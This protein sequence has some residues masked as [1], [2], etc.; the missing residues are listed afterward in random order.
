MSVSI[1]TMIEKIK[2]T[3][4][5]ID[6][7]TK[8]VLFSNQKAK[9][10]IGDKNGNIDLDV[11]FDS[12]DIIDTFLLKRNVGEI[13]DIYI[14]IAKSNEL[15][16]V[17]LYLG[18]FDQAKTQVYIE[19]QPKSDIKKMFEAMQELSTDILFMINID[20]HLLFFRGEL[21]KQLGL[22]ENIIN[23]PHALIEACVIHPEDIDTYLVT[24]D[25][26]LDGIQRSCELR[27]K[28]A[29]GNFN[30]FSLT[31]V[32]VYND[33]R[34][35]IKVLGK[36]Q[37][38]Q[39]EKDLQF[40]MSHDLLTKTLNKISLTNC[41]TEILHASDEGET[42]ALY[43]IDVD[44]FSSISA[45]FTHAFGDKLL[46]NIGRILLSCVRDT[47]LVG[48]V[49]IDEFVVFL[50]NIV[51]DDAIDKKAE[52]IL[53]KLAQEFKYEGKSYT[54]R[55]SI[56][57]A[58]YPNHGTTY[59]ELQKKADIALYSSKEKGKNISTIFNDT[60]G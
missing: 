24:A 7:T 33:Y 6:K 49:G 38:I 19:M 21:S 48:R 9:Q 25:D 17:N 26:M 55:A 53:K 39:K 36:L 29:N 50:P 8:E 51:S 57:I 34:Q 4:I 47:D 35:P 37:N 5:V 41:I 27:I 28:L 43:F 2:N 59:N 16:L 13:P 15:K 18:F 46:A 32:I 14:T 56:G 31:S 42:H 60:L 12:T 45:T 58:K 44:D 40:K 10:F 23:F 11:V 30:W 20:K 1:I 54:A 22:H 52:F 3:Y